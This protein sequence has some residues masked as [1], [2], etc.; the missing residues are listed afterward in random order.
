SGL[1]TTERERT[2]AERAWLRR[3]GVPARSRDAFLAAC[4]LDDDA[5]RTLA[6]DLALEARLLGMAERAVPDGPGWDEGLALEARLSGAWIE[7]A[8]LAVQGAG[9]QR[10]APRARGGRAARAPSA[11]RRRP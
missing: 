6:E 9:R 10:A 4:G 2:A 5:A 3:L 1:T 11:V 7:E 8:R